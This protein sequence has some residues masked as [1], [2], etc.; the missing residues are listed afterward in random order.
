MTKQDK[1]NTRYFVGDRECAHVYEAVQ[2]GE[3]LSLQVFKEVSGDPVLG[4]RFLY[5]DGGWVHIGRCPVR[6]R[7]VDPMNVESTPEC[8]RGC[9]Y[10]QTFRDFAL[11]RNALRME[12]AHMVNPNRCGWNLIPGRSGGY[13]LDY[14]PC[15]VHA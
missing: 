1:S 8:N 9:T 5:K 10:R 11:Q 15:W 2:R 7:P 13:P 3:L 12:T 14:A 6:P 4:G